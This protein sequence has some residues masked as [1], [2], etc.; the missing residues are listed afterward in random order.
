MQALRQFLA[1]SIRDLQQT[2]FAKAD[3]RIA[4]GSFKTGMT[5]L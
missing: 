4:S 1:S 3:L 2:G 5:L